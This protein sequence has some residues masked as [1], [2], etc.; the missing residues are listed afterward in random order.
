M[1]NRLLREMLNEVID[2]LDMIKIEVM[3]DD[4]DVHNINRRLQ[5]LSNL[6]IEK[7][8]ELYLLESK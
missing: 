4:P 2:D 6:L 3:G 5:D 8:H 1:N 7:E